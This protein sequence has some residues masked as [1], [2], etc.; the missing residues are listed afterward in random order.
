MR[1]LLPVLFFLLASAQTPAP[2]GPM[3]TQPGDKADGPRAPGKG[4]VKRAPD[5]APG[6]GPSA[7]E[8]QHEKSQPK[9]SQTQP[10][11]EQPKAGEAQREKGQKSTQG[12]QPGGEHRVQVSEQQRSSVRE[13][14][15]RSATLPKIMPPAAQ[16]ISRIEV[17]IPVH[18]SVAALASV[19]PI[20]SPSNV[21]TQ[22]GAT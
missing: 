21:G 13:R 14:P 15:M 3:R 16:P 1:R 12:R 8:S 6:K 22:F 20:A 5:S 4:E 7:A 11:K 17:S 19:E 2:Q 10:Q 18:C 9:S